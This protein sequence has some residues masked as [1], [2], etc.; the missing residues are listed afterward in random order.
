MR[1]LRFVWDYALSTHR[2]LCSTHSLPTVLVVVHTLYAPYLFFVF[3]FFFT[4]SKQYS[5][6]IKP[7]LNEGSSELNNEFIQADMMIKEEKT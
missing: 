3:L 5:D 6:T 7:K 4:E 2:L 1:V